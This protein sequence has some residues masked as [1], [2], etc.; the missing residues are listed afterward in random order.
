MA[1][2]SLSA[3]AAFAPPSSGPY[4]KFSDIPLK[5]APTASVDQTNAEMATLRGMAAELANQY[6]GDPNQA[7]DDASIAAARAVASQVQAPTA[8]DD[9]AT[10]AFV[11]AARARATPPPARKN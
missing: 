3:C 6:A 4:P 10:D 7:A 5:A 11:R 8:E 2:V 1:G 9:A